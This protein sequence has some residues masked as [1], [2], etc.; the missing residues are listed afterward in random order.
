MKA[1][2]TCRINFP[3][4]HEQPTQGIVEGTRLEKGLPKQK[5]YQIVIHTPLLYYFCLSDA[6][7]LS[8]PSIKFRSTST[9]WSTG[10][11]IVHQAKVDDT[12]QR[13]H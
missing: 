8:P 9:I 3:L 2:E 11:R 7:P 13:S 1:K 5:G 12:D 6:V 10:R 4:V